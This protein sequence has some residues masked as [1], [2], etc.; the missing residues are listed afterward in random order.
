MTEDKGILIRNIYYMLAYAFQ[1]LRQ[2]NYAEIQGES[3]NDIYDLFA[4][5]LAK[6]ISYQIKQGLYREYVTLNESMQTV[7]GKIDING[8]LAKR[9]QNCQHIVCN[10]DELSENNIYNQILVTTTLILIRHSDVRQEKKAQLKK[11]ILFFQNV[12]TIDI[13]TI[14][15]NRLRF[16][17]N[18][19]NYQMLIYICYFIINEWLLTT[20]GGK[21]KISSFSDNHMCRIFEKFV[22]AFYKKHHPEVKA[23][24]AQIGYPYYRH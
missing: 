9:S 21:F 8:T 24:A 23:Y 16:D 19:R 6:G 3:F 2:N 14:Q 7:R 13:H 20:K 22:L 5:I 1:E 17:R 15:W 11:I 4:E 12:N 10:Y 18:N